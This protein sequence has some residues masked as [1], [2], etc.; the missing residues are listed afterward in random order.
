MEL[1]T[2]KCFNSSHNWRYVLPAAWFSP[3]SEL[4]TNRKW[5]FKTFVLSDFYRQWNSG[6][7]LKQSST[8]KD[9]GNSKNVTFQLSSCERGAYAAYVVCLDVAYTASIISVC[10]RIVSGQ[11][12]SFKENQSWNGYW[13]VAGVEAEAEAEALSSSSLSSSLDCGT[14]TAGMVAAGVSGSCS[15]LLFRAKI[16]W[17]S[18]AASWPMSLE[19]PWRN[20][21]TQHWRE[22]NS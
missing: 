13:L 8:G 12:F 6:S 9:S 19:L 17:C 20:V 3:P 21:H 16:R 1:P 10:E 7:G 5:W 4:P 15:A 22:S 14:S 2:A 18:A 11:K